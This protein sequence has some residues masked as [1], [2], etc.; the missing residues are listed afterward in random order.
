MLLGVLTGTT[1]SGKSAL[2]LEFAA[3]RGCEIVGADS[4]QIYRGFRI[5][6][7]QPSAADLARAVHR[8]VDCVPPEENFSAGAFA[9]AVLDLERSSPDVPRVVVGGTGFYVSALVRGLPP[10]PPVGADVRAAVLSELREKGVEALHAELSEVD[11]EAAARLPLSDARRISRAL[12]V[13]RATGRPFSSWKG[14]AEAPFPDLPVAVLEPSPEE[15]RAR[16]AKRV[17]GMFRAGWREE[18]EGLLRAG[19]PESAPAFGSLGYP[20]VL[21]LLKGEIS[22]A[23]AIE[24]AIAKSAQ[25]AKRQRTYF[26]G[27]FPD[28]VRLDPGS[29]DAADLARAFGV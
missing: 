27:Q 17:R 29:A 10:I 16:I 7:G 13:W 23:E 9:S 28:A 12:E 22:E 4:R 19:V 2:A 1:A 6:T 25:Y 21:G 20:Q 18:V 11:P 24:T 14:E 8:L 3:A 26:R 15:N 5:G